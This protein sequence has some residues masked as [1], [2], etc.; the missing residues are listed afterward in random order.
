VDTAQLKVYKNKNA[1]DN[2]E[3][4][5]DDREIGNFGNSEEKALIVVV[6]IP[7]PHPMRKQR[8]IQLNEILSSSSKRCFSVLSKLKQDQYEPHPQ[9]EKRWIQLNEIL[10][11]M[12]AKRLK[13]EDGKS[14]SYVRWDQAKS[15]FCPKMYTQQRLDIAEEKL[16]FLAQYLLLTTKCFADITTGS[17]SKRLHLI[18]PILT[19]I[20]MLF[21]DNNVEIIVDEDMDGSFIKASAHF[22]FIIRHGKKLICITLAKKDDL[23]QGM[24]QNLMGCE[25][26]AE[27][28]GLDAVYG[29]VTNYVQWNFVCS[30]NEKIEFEECSISLTRNGDSLKAIA[31]KIYFIL[32][33]G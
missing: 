6:S 8:W 27:I 9:R 19:C 3:K 21:D 22:E 7:T 11:S 10:D 16:Q 13:N 31:E 1:F 4:E 25:V 5:I 20:C 17:D 32:S 14:S 33:D 26:A 18:A 24:V 12:N 23:E 29:I 30:R 2:G 28:C 15:V